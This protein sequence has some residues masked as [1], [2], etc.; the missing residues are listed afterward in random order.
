MISVL[1]GLVAWM[2]ANNSSKYIFGGDSAEFSAIAHN[3]SIAHPP[4][5]PLY[6]FL[7]NCLT[8][9]I[10][11]GTIPWRASLLSVL[12]TVLSS[13]ILYKIFLYLRIKKVLS[14]LIS[15]LYIALFPVWEYALVPEVF[16]LNSFFV[17]LI[18]YFL[19]R[20]IDSK[21]LI[22]IFCSAFVGGLCVSHHHIFVIFIPGWMYLLKDSYKKIIQNNRAR[23]IS[24]LFFIAGLSFYLYAPIA[25]HFNPPI[26]WEDAKTI[27]GFWRLIT[28]AMYGTFTAYGGSRGNIVNQLYDIF[29]SFVFIFQ[30]F[31]ILGSCI[32]L[33]GIWVANKR[34]SPL[35]RFIFITSLVHVLFIFYTNFMLSS[36]FSIGMYERF[37][38][39]FYA[40]LIIYFG[41]GYDALYTYTVHFVSLASQRRG[42]QTLTKYTLIL[43]LAIYIGTLV[44]T[45]YRALS[46]IKN[47]RDFER[48]GI[49]LA[50]TT[51]PGS[52][53]FPSNDNSNFATMWQVFG[54][55]NSSRSIFFQ[56]HFIDKKFYIDQFKKKYP[57]LHYPQS[58]KSSK[59]FG[60]FFSLNAERGI[61][62]ETPTQDGFWMPYGL[63]WKYYNS[64]KEGLADIPHLIDENAQLWNSVYHI[65]QLTPDTRNILH[66]QAVQDF[67][68]ESYMTYAKLLFYAKENKMAQQVMEDIIKNYRPS[69]DHARMILLNLLVLERNCSEAKNIM[70]KFNSISPN[71]LQNEYILPITNYYS[72]CDPHNEALP[73]MKE[74]MKEYK[75]SSLT[76]LDRF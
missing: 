37:L 70:K 56:A 17:L 57:L 52:I 19:L 23:A 75:E 68:I 66:L 55:G 22:Y 43:V 7:L 71:S 49:D 38:I 40:L 46:V 45:N 30:D 9:F 60:A 63:L 21:K 61:Y 39:S 29:S 14:L 5:Y 13:Y 36:S 27:D 42:L 8:H 35:Y 10:P 31:R 11:F 12:P 44:K 74:R 4:G 33:L 50:N 3:W 26:Q 54:E 51:P 6:S 67:Y 16:A 41:I 15:L 76:P 62:F 58:L 48:L 25:S 2:L 64:Q 53:Y 73:L 24:A 59:D 65:P 47:G 32:I 69:N 28:R 34:N 72:Q 1:Y 18:T 20:F